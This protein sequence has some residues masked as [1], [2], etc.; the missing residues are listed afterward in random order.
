ML[1]VASIVLTAVARLRR[2][3][4]PVAIAAWAATASGMSAFMLSTRVH[5]RYALPVLGLSLLMGATER[6]G[7]RATAFFWCVS[8]CLTVNLVLVLYGGLHGPGDHLLSFGHTWWVGL[9]AGYCALTAVL[10]TWPW[11]PGALQP[12]PAPGPV[13]GAVPVDDRLTGA[14]TGHSRG[15]LSST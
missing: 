9:A 4:D 10:L 15:E 1:A 8:A 3:A 5:E 7:R 6:F 12:G 14:S 2:G 13:R 11:Y